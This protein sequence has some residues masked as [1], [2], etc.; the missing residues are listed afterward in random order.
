MVAL[1]G[2]VSSVTG[3]WQLDTVA[4]GMGPGG[5]GNVWDGNP[6]RTF[7]DGLGGPA[8]CDTS[9]YGPYGPCG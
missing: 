2:G 9:A 8:T 3:V 5:M 1:V 6:R 7:M 4:G